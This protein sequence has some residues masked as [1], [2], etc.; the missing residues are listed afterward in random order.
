MWAFAPNDVWAGS[1]IM[2]H[3]DGTAFTPVTTPAIGFV[4]DF[5]GFAPDDLYAVSGVSLLHWDGSAWSVIDFADAIDPT[6]LTAVWGTSGGDLWLGDSL[7]GQVFHWNGTSWSTGIP[8]TVEVQDLWGSRAV[9]LRGRHFGL[10]QWNGSAWIEIEV[11]SV[12]SEASGMWGFG[13]GDVWTASDF[14]TLAHLGRHG[15]DG[16][17]PADEPTSRTPHVGVGS[18]ARRRLGGRRRRRE[19]ALGRRPLEPESGRDVSLLPVSQQGARL[20][21]GDVWVVGRSSDGTN[22][23]VILHNGP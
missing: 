4:A 13:T 15:V 7:N 22:A 14:G 1:K 21:A 20:V 9:P 2:M 11:D 6:D 16:Q 19:S 17:L 3:F 5:W 18:G 8:Q 10:S 23:G 12:A